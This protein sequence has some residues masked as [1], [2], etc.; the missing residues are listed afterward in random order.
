MYRLMQMPAASAQVEHLNAWKNHNDNVLL[1]VIV[2]AMNVSINPDARKTSVLYLRLSYHPWET[3]KSKKFRV[4]AFGR[5]TWE[6]LLSL[7]FT[8]AAV[9]N[10]QADRRAG[11]ERHRHAAGPLGVAMA[12]L[13]ARAVGIFT[14]APYAFPTNAVPPH[15]EEWD[16]VLQKMIDGHGA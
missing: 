16:S 12:V 4:A 2:S 7:G 1:N 9:A 5:Y 6:T 14:S 15:L 10:I 3:R 8:E 13:D 11:E